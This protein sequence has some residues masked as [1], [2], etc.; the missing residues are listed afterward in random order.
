MKRP[1][2]HRIAARV[3]LL[4]FTSCMVACGGSEGQPPPPTSTAPPATMPPVPTTL[5]PPPPTEPPPPP[6]PPAPPPTLPAQ[7]PAQLNKQELRDL[8][9]P[10]ALYPDVVL[11]SLLP[12]S[13]NA[14]QIH[15]AAQYVGNAQHVDQVPQDRGWDGSVV[16]LLQFPD[17]LRWL[18]Q[19]PAWTD[20][21]G[22]AVTYQQGDVLQAIQDYRHAV[23]DVG[24]LK[25]N[26]YQVVSAEPGQDIRIEPA[27]PDVV[28]VPSYDPALAVQPQ[29][30]QPAPGINPWIAFGGGAVVGALGAWALYS[31]FDSDHGGTHVTNNY[32]GGGGGGYNRQIHAYNNY[33]YARGRRPQQVQ[34]TP[35]PRA[36]RARVEGWQHPRRFEA[37]PATA[38]ATRATALRPPMQATTTGPG[39]APTPAQLRREQQQERRTQ[40]QQNRQQQEQLRQQNRQQRQEQKQQNRQQRQEF[41]Q[42][43]RQQQQQMRQERQQEQRNQREQRQQNRE[44]QQ[45]QRQQE[46]QQQQQQRQQQRQ[47]ERQQQQQQRKEQHQQQGGGQNNKKKKQQQGQ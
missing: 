8:V 15:D 29:P 1:G 21:M 2:W 46:R 10:V 17:V 40:Q 36:Q 22:Q 28:Y 45:Q 24:N 30:A 42:Q 38:Q 47:Q 11:A 35:R 34:W 23:N 41:Q 6:Q 7:P 19:N 20:Q 31:I 14:D 18:D 44:Q 12:A 43:N 25:S 39:A 32:Y 37:R 26:Q 27:H 9:A 16:G 4:T 33:Y 3:V 5:P 13:T